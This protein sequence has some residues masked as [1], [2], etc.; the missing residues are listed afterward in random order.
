M[1]V[2]HVACFDGNTLRLLGIARELY[3]TPERA[4]MDR[5]VYPL[6]KQG[7]FPMYARQRCGTGILITRVFA[8]EN[9]L[10][11]D[12]VYFRDSAEISALYKRAPLGD[13]LFFA[14]SARL[15]Q[16]VA[17][18]LAVLD[19]MMPSQTLRQTQAMLKS[20]M[21]DEETVAALLCAL[22][23]GAMPV[24]LIG[25]LS[26]ADFSHRLFLTLELM[27]MTLPQ[28]S[29]AQVE[30]CTLASADTM[31]RG[32]NGFTLNDDAPGSSRYMYLP[33]GTR[34]LD[35]TPSRGDHERAAALLNGKPDELLKNW[36]SVKDDAPNGEG[37]PEAATDANAA[38]EQAQISAQDLE[39]AQQAL[40]AS[41]KYAN[42]QEFRRFTSG[43]FHKRG[44]MDSSLYFRYSLMYCDYLHRL[45]HPM[46]EVYDA[47]LAALYADPPQ[48]ILASQI[49]LTLTGYP[50]ALSGAVR[51]MSSKEEL[52]RFVGDAMPRMESGEKP[53]AY[54]QRLLSVCGTLMNSIPNSTMNDLLPAAL[55]AANTSIPIAIHRLDA[56]TFLRVSDSIDMLREAE[57]SLDDSAFDRMMS[58]LVE[59]LEFKRLDEYDED[60][61]R[62]LRFANSYVSQ[63]E[64][65]VTDKQRAVYLWGRLMEGR[66]S[67]K[68][69][70]L[71]S[72]IDLLSPMSP[73]NRV[74][75]ISFLRRYYKALCTDGLESDQLTN[76]VVTLALI[77]ALKFDV[78]GNAHIGAL[79]DALDTLSTDN[80]ERERSFWRIVNSH[81]NLVSYPMRTQLRAM[82]REREETEEL[83]LRKREME[84][85]RYVP[86]EGNYTRLETADSAVDTAETAQAETTAGSVTAPDAEAQAAESVDLHED[87]LPRRKPRSSAQ[88]AHSRAAEADDTRARTA[89][90]ARASG[91]HTNQQKAGGNRNAAAPKKRSKQKGR[92]KG[93]SIALTVL[94]ILLF[95]V[96]VY[97]AY[98]LLT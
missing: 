6:L 73:V 66:S 76:S 79:D 41:L 29:A 69:S 9:R 1:A 25:R 85:Q 46:Q 20:L 78:D 39:K 4:E 26:A 82:E 88:G 17:L 33:D 47:E 92:I 23:T 30:Y 48:G 71:D 70:M 35:V 13:G 86:P 8:V 93:D 18:P 62:C 52:A 77:T 89:S 5:L 51:H 90:K 45:G 32:V 87:P 64:E 40:S 24:T 83:R 31:S 56:S 59:R 16:V 65:K 58:R 28:Q 96:L 80:L 27:I 10:I 49:A 42:S 95:L 63:W 91:K 44:E 38:S 37:S 94:F 72:M 98:N 74:D 7:R 81:E 15:K 11:A 84:K 60:T 43:F 3:Q 97:C 61:Y 2:R 75:F 53:D 67:Q 55:E 12:S 19:E 14:D 22:R 50:G 34:D 36:E 68:Q 21:S 57:P 54:T